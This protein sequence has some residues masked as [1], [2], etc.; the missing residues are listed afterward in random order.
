MYNK[1]LSDNTY[2]V[3]NDQVFNI[4]FPY[5]DLIFKYHDTLW[6][7][8]IINNDIIVNDKGTL[9]KQKITSME[10]SSIITED[11]Y[12]DYSQSMDALILERKEAYNS[13]RMKFDIL[14]ENK[15]RRY[16]TP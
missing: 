6:K 15:P 13:K 12:L 4:C 1:E 2:P 8:T 11:Q 16:E 10:V 9:M 5:S 14:V 3:Q 7:E